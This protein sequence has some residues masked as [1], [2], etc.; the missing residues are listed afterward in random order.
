MAEGITI[1][2][3]AANK[4]Y[5][6]KIATMPHTINPDRLAKSPK[7]PMIETVVEK[8]VLTDD[9]RTIE[10]YH[11]PTDHAS[12]MLVGYLPKEKILYE[13]DVFNAPAANAPA[14]TAINP[15]TTQF[16]DQL[17]KMKLDVNQVLPGHG[18]GAT[19]IAALKAAAGK[20]GAA[21]N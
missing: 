8:K 4:P 20:S 7:A 17:V 14:P 1:L 11:V 21:A 3:Q 16:Y 5:Y 18:P 10:I 2:T 15:A 6:E 12:T 13:V 9:T 19:T